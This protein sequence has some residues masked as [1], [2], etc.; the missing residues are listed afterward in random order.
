MNPV[1]FTIIVVVVMITEGS[2]NTFPCSYTKKS[3]FQWSWVHCVRHHTEAVSDLLKRNV[4]GLPDCLFL[5][6]LVFYANSNANSNSTVLD[7]GANIGGCTALLTS[8]GFYVEAFEPSETNAAYIYHTMQI[9]NFKNYKIRTIALG[10]QTK[11]TFIMSQSGNMGN[12]QI[13]DLQNTL[14]TDRVNDT[15]LNK[16]AIDTLML[17]DVIRDGNDIPF[18]KLDVQGYETKVL[19]GG[20]QTLKK[21]VVGAILFECE[22]SRLWAHQ[23]S[24]AHLF[25]TLQN[26]GFYIISVQGQRISNV[27]MMNFVCGEKIRNLYGSISLYALHY[28]KFNMINPKTRKFMKCIKNTNFNSEPGTMYS[29]CI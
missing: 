22:D 11:R 9:N 28:K 1:F 24:P 8:A 15:M 12:T 21:G 23:S 26:F 7:I 27:R 2:V 6:P 20:S 25:H 5:L 10:D 14:V 18:M 13:V 4:Y 16:T 19:L 3:V 17:D 29:H